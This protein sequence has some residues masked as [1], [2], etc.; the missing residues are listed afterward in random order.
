MAAAVLA[1]MAG[2]AEARVYSL[3]DVDAE[4]TVEDLH[5][6]RYLATDNSTS[7]AA[8]VAAVA[9]VTIAAAAVIA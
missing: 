5:E 9:G 2:S 4:N 1:L 3:N 8:D 6:F 7:S